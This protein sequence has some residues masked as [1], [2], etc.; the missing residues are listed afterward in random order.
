M[1]GKRGGARPGAGR[2]PGSPNKVPFTIRRTVA[3]MAATY[4]EEA[5]EVL[6]QIMRTG[7]SD[8]ARVNAAN[9][10]LDRAHGK[11]GAAEDGSD[12]EAVS[13]SVTINASPA[14]AEVRVTRS[15]G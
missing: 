10:L 12:D 13:L 7:N 9:S 1:P 6:A 11:V 14:V 4:T 15:D 2:K 3:E 8:A 5:L